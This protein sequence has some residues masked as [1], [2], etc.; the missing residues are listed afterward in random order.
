[1]RPDMRYNDAPPQL[2]EITGDV[3]NACFE[4]HSALGPGLLEHVYQAAL[5]EELSG[6]G[7]H[8][9]LE[10]PVSLRYKSV[11]LPIAFRMDVVV[12]RLVVVEIKTVE[13]L[14]PIHFAQLDT[15]LEGSRLPVGLL[16]NFNVASLKG[17]L[18]RRARSTL[19]A[20]SVGPRSPVVPERQ[21]AEDPPAP[22]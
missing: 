16:V 2:N 19:R 12:D 17:S 5:A 20:Y 18:H 6:R 11:A 14:A 3:V 7:R 10:V 15:Y 1:M 13:A 21:A 8:V 9:E 4:V 22:E